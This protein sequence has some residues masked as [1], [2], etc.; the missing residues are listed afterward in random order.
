MKTIKY[1]PVLISAGLLSFAASGCTD[2]LDQ[3]PMSSNTTA[4]YFQNQEQFQNAANYLMGDIYAFGRSFSSNDSFSVFF[5]YG[6]DLSGQSNDEVSG[7]NGAPDAE[8]YYSTPYTSLFRINAVLAQAES[9]KGDENIDQPVGQAYFC[10]AMWDFFLLKRYGGVTLVSRAIDTASEEVFGP[11]NSR[12]EVVQQI[13]DDLDQAISLLSST[14]KSSTSND[15][16]VTVEA[17]TA[18]KARVCLFEGTWETYNGRGSNDSTNGDGVT[19]GAGT[20]MPDNYPSITELLT[21]ARDCAGAF[22]SGGKYASEYSIWMP[23]NTTGL[24]VYDEQEPYYYFIL[25]DAD[26]NPY[27]LNKASNDEAIYRSVF[28]YDNNSKDGQNLS[29]T[30]PASASR[31]LMDM[32]LCT[33]GLPI[34]ISPLFKGYAGTNDEFLN[35]D[36][37]M[38]SLFKQAGDYYWTCSGE[39]GASSDY[40]TTPELGGGENFTP[41]LTANSANNIAYKGRKFVF[42]R[43]RT[44]TNEAYDY[45]HIRLPEMLL[46]YAEAVYELNG[47]IS[48]SDLDN[49]VNVIRKRARIADLTNSLVNTNGLSMLEEIRR[50]RAIELFGEGFRFSDLCR[51]G[52]AEQELTRPRCSYY[53]TYE[54]NTTGIGSSSFYDASQFS[55]YITT[56]EEAQ[57]TYTAGMPTLK[58]GA[59]IMEQSNNRIFSKKNYL[60]AIPRTQISLNPNLLQ[61]PSW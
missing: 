56:A 24:D 9:Y 38:V 45:N 61:N 37:R 39:T 2:W 4:M 32:F 52:I 43:D 50:E 10:R 17:A 49:T 30:Y 59:L 26:S 55:G 46:T 8:N 19:S 27:G 14:T 42:E 41:T 29:H 57:S 33:D 23:V 35:R 25:E 22:V 18:L 58:A 51:W 20:T 12:Y 3:E 21:M 36:A 48:D 16:Q 5:D 11:R 1:I 31:K 40:T 13:L 53:V 54:G 47:S 28:D 15:G 34:N 60:Q 44:T 7:L 6:T